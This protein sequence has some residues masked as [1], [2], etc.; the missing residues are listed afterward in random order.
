MHKITLEKTSNTFFLPADA[1]RAVYCAVPNDHARPTAESVPAAF[2]LSKM[3]LFQKACAALHP[4]N[5]GRDAV[6]ITAARP[7]EGMRVE[8]A[9]NPNLLG[10]LM[11]V[12]F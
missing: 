7:G 12:K 4:G 1:L 2:S 6:R 10:V 3:S 11:P 8:F 5:S 9:S